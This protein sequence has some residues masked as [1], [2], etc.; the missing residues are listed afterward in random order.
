MERRTFLTSLVALA[1]NGSLVARAFQQPQAGGERAVKIEKLKY[2]LFLLR[3]GGGN[4]AVFVTSTGAVVIDTK[5]PGW[6][7]P[8]IDAV[9]TITDKP[10]TRIIN[11]HT[12]ADHVSGNVEFPASVDVVAH[13][14]ARVGMEKMAPVTGMPTTVGMPHIFKEHG[15]KGLPKRT[16]KDRLTI[17]TGADQIDLYYFGRGHTDGDAWVV[18][19]ALRMMHAGDIFSGKGVPLLDANNGGSGVEIGSSLAKAAAGIRGI[20][21]IIT[22]HDGVLTMPDLEE[23]VRFNDEFLATVRN[24][25]RAGRTIDEVVASWRMPEKYVEYGAAQPARVRSNVEVVYNE[26]Q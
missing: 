18:F 15:G 7:Q 17:G 12:H 14:N 8:I 21:A 1:A 4:T 25:K 6:G 3:G 5:N 10:V 2:N 19:P 26:L 16:F 13:D 9:K 22:G 23:Y 11:T 24:A 20:D